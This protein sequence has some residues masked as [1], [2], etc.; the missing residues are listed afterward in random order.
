MKRSK[1]FRYYSL[2]DINPVIRI[3]VFSDILVVGAA[4]MLSP[5]FAIFIKD[6]I[7]GGNE[8]VAGIAVAIYLISK[9]VLQI[10]AA[11]VIDKI[12]GEKD[13][14]SMMT[15]FTLLMSLVPLLYLVI[16]TPAQLYGVQL[17]L[18]LF[19][20][21]TFP[22]F[23]AIFTRHIDKTREGTEW[24]VY[25]TLVDLS[26]AALA[27]I[28]GYIAYSIGFPQLIVYVVALSVIGSIVLFPIRRYMYKR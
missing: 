17:L 9:S 11:A 28:G 8:A 26:S 25:F 18:G 10:P 1:G 7:Q 5:I 15:L 6:Y 22:S 21:M 23:M 16:K 20:A 12:K 24:G 3:L 27:A 13:D 14:F 4:A 2:K 19:T